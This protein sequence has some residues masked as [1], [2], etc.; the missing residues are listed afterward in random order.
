[1]MPIERIP[2]WERRLARQDAFWDCAVLDRPVVTI[3]VPR[4]V[5]E[6]PW[7]AE[8]QYAT[9]RDRWMDTER[10]VEDALAA[11][12]NTE[13]LGDALPSAWPNLGPE[14][15][16][17]FFG[18]DLEYTAD[19]SW[20]VPA[21][22]DWADVS[23]LRFS[24]DNP[25]WKKLL[26]MTDALLDAGKG[27]Y[28]V[29]I[30]DIHPGGDA[31][32]AFREPIDLNTDLLTAPDAVK[33]LLRHVNETYAGVFDFYYDKL[34]K[35]GQACTSWPGIVSTRKWYV[36]SNDFSCMI[37]KEMFDEFFLPGII[38]ECRHT[39][40]S[41]YHLDGPGALRHLDSLLAI[42]ELNAIQ[43]VYGAGNGT[44]SDWTAVYQRCQQ[45]GKGIQLSLVLRELDWLFEN[46]RPEGVWLGV[47]GV[48]DA[49]CAAE[50]IRRVGAWR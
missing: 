43:W 7:P 33:A 30:S 20:A 14:V 40:A 48:T 27:V 50:V 25:Y 13:Y 36:P 4:P 41:I 29:G 16:S 1:M 37:S 47:G 28:Y 21:V 42:E 15:F 17:A 12:L 45:A 2:D 44:A 32:A 8:K 22:T 9:Y 19:T 3:S 18:I 31:I 38:E 11:A 46:L 24:E 49:E 39:E 5:P 10:V 23:H 6:R 34:T 26:E 35:A